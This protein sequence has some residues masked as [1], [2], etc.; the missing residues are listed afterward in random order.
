MDSEYCDAINELLNSVE[1]LCLRVEELYNKAEVQSIN[2]SKGDSSDVGVFSDNA[3]VTIYE[4]LEVMEIAYLGWRIQ[5][6]KPTHYTTS[7][8]LRKSRVS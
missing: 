6:R 1:D 5:S 7:I 2:S 4:F 3:K 8:Y